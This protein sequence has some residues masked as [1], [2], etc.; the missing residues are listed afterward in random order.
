MANL[1]ETVRSLFP[2]SVLNSRLTELINSV[3]EQTR[4]LYDGDSSRFLNEVG[5]TV[6]EALQN[7]RRLPQATG[8]PKEILP[9]LFNDFLN[10]AVN[11]HSPNLQYNVGA[12]TMDAATAAYALSLEANLFMINSGLAGNSIA[13]ENAVSEILADLA[14]IEKETVGIFSYGGSAT[15]AYAIRIG[16][17]KAYPALD[18]KGMPAGLLKLLIT[19]DAHFAHNR[20]A[21][22]QGLGSNNVIMIDHYEDRRTSVEDAEKKMRE[23]FESG[24][25]IGTIIINGG[26]TYQHNIDDIEAFV[27]LRDRIVEDYE[28]D[29]VPHIH[30]DSVIGWAWLMFNDYDYLTNPL[31]LSKEAL[32]N[33]KIQNQRISKVYL[34]DSW[35]VD[36]HKG[37]GSVPCVSSIIM[38]NNINDLSF[39]CEDPNTL[40]QVDP[41][42]SC[43]NPVKFTLE[44]SRTSGGALAALTALH[45]LWR[46]G[47]QALLG[48]LTEASVTTKKILE[49][50]AYIATCSPEHSLGYVTMIRMLPPEI[51]DPNAQIDYDLYDLGEL[52]PESTKMINEYMRGFVE[53]DKQRINKSGNGVEYSFS[54]GFINHK[55]CRSVSAIKFYPVSPHTTSE[56]IKDAVE[57]LI[58]QKEIYDQT[59]WVNRNG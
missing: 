19:Q 29:Y 35:G 40:H 13:A 17:K 27:N 3:K 10:G 32:A 33:T 51:E 24:G 59:V 4:L 23:I 41:E 20:S 38:L 42:H 1:M 43:L 12:P 6:Q 37:V 8:D 28:L 39:L 22:W 18:N 15:N 31:K 50:H 56:T 30:V 16:L 45:V 11:W 14:G 57:T 58:R 53:W 52:N 7:Y 36:F 55:E 49:E 21:V 47:Y 5:M 9:Q 48:N 2:R 26:T 25:R 46:G 44:T 34:A 54:N